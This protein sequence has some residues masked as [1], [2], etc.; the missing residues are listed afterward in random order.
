[1]SFDNGKYLSFEFKFL[2]LKFSIERLKN[3]M[4]EVFSLMI[5][6]LF[7]SQISE[8]LSVFARLSSLSEILRLNS[9][10]NLKAQTTTTTESFRI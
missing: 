10:Q 1:M 4:G 7:P 6:K 9:S 3:K 5:L 8:K 2:R